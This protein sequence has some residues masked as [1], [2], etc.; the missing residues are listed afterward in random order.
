MTQGSATKYNRRSERHKRKLVTEDDN[1][2]EWKL[3]DRKD[4]YNKLA[5]EVVI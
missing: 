2:I 1:S 5:E 3:N 4:F